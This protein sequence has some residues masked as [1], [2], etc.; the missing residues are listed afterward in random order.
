MKQLPVFLCI[1]LCIAFVCLDGLSLQEEKTDT[2]TV[3]VSG[4]VEEEKILELARYSVLQDALDETEISEDADL[5]SLNPQTVLKDKDCIVIPEKTEE[6]RISINTASAEELIKLP[7][8][9][10]A[11]AEKIIQY[12]EE[13]GL[14]QTAEDLMNVKGIG[15]AKFEKVKDL[16]C[17]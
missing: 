2:I 11:T 3:T 8:I 7:G 6:E 4:A 1:L 15:P 14:F 10:P 5:T 12:R 9:G 17:L 16:I 13:N